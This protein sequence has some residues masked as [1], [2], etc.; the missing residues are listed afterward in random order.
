MEG[1]LDDICTSGQT[2]AALDLCVGLRPAMR[3]H[4]LQTGAG[5]YGVFNGRRWTSEIYPRVRALVQGNS[6]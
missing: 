1:E 6:R 5:H 4:H 3:R 2:M